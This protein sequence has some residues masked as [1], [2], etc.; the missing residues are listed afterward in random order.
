MGVSQKRICPSLDDRDKTRW[1]QR[2]IFV[3]TESIQSI[4][5]IDTEDKSQLDKVAFPASIG[6]HEKQQSE[7]VPES[8]E[9]CARPVSVSTAEAVLHK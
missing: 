5:R 6:A 3:K 4:L 1:L 2:Q 7:I 9:L 8:F